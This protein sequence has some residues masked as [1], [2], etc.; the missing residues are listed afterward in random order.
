LPEAHELD[1]PSI[2]IG[3]PY[4]H[5]E[6]APFYEQFP[7]HCHD[8]NW[9]YADEE[10]FYEGFNRAQQV[11]AIIN[12]RPEKNLVLVS[13]GTF[14]TIFLTMMLFPQKFNLEL[15]LRLHDFA[16]LKNTGITVYER[17][18]N[19]AWFLRTLNDFAT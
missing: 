1:K 9:H 2:T 13:H 14:L 8:P 16:H 4:G 19:K 11:F 10:N 18:P 5:P 15:F 17:S 7:K 12:R 3:K 6:V